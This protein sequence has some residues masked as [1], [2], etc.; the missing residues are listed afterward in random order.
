MGSRRSN[1]HESHSAGGGVCEALGCRALYSDT[2]ARVVFAHTGS[3]LYP[4]LQMG[5]LRLQAVSCWAYA[6]EEGGRP[7]AAEALSVGEGRP[8]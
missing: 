6:W 4:H 8:C 1:L 2:L 7:G 3:Q 5:K